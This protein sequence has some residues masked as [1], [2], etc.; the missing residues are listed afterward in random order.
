MV[1]N[2]LIH[3]LVHY[4]NISGSNI[5]KKE[6]RKRPVR[7]SDHLRNCLF[8]DGLFC[9]KSDNYIQI[10][11]CSFKNA[12]L[13]YVNC[14]VELFSIIKKHYMFWFTGMIEAPLISKY[15]YEYCSG[16][17]R[18][19]QQSHRLLSLVQLSLSNAVVG[20]L[21][22]NI[23]YDLLCFQ[24]IWFKPITWQFHSEFTTYLIKCLIEN[25][26]SG[27]NNMSHA[28]VQ[29]NN[30]SISW[31]FMRTRCKDRYFGLFN[32]FLLHE[33]NRINQSHKW[34]RKER[35]KV[36]FSSADMPC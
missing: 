25:I 8:D 21:F 15:C 18:L 28:Y 34:V 5:T 31:F 14:Q 23:F 29:Y 26:N 4:Q 16:T 11:K 20:F 30:H 1:T 12:P 24:A 3:W 19:S 33:K 10:D 36:V 22:E 17:N 32:R 6:E 2:V 35:L 13:N 27:I 9:I 7:L